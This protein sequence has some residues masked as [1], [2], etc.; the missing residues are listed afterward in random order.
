M[1]A[2]V[3]LV[4]SALLF[5]PLMRRIPLSQIAAL[6]L[7]GAVQF[8]L[9]YCLYLQSFQYLQ[10]HH[11]A[12]LTITTPI[13][14]LGI[15]TCM[16]RRLRTRHVLAAL[17]AVTAA[18]LLVMDSFSWQATLWGVIWMQAAN[19]CFAAGQLLYRRVMAPSRH[20]HHAVFSYVY[21][22]AC[23]VPSVWIASTGQADFG[24]SGPQWAALL[25]L[26]LIPSG[27]AFFLW[28]LG[29][30][31]SRPAT[32][33]VMNNAKIPVA[34]MVSFLV[35]GEHPQWIRLLLCLL[36]FLTALR[37]TK[38][39]NEGSSKSESPCDS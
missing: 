24:F 31:R 1:V 17:L 4:L 34:V 10:A 39:S 7:V 30:S 14:V 18:A 16:S 6:A 15:E 2:W 29:A 13:Y 35:F 37:L 8:G 11:V 38:G 23:L 9:M 25:Y 5:L 3:R 21:A 12:A 33:A 26:G 32:L 27:L 22:G 36:V 20:P 19:V 28:N